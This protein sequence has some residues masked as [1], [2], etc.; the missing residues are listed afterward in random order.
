MRNNEN[1]DNIIPIVGVI[2][3]G[4]LSY[5][6]F[7]GIT[8]DKDKDGNGDGT[9]PDVPPVVPPDVPPVIT[10]IPPKPD[11]VPD[12]KVEIGDVTLTS[13]DGRT[14]QPAGTNVS[15]SIPVKNVSGRP[16]SFSSAI[17]VR[18]TKDLWIFGSDAPITGLIQGGE[19]IF[20]HNETRLY[21]FPW[22]TSGEGTFSIIVYVYS[23]S[24][25]I[26]RR[27]YNYSSIR[28]IIPV[29]LTI[30]YNP[31]NVG[32]VTAKYGNET[33]YNARV[34]TVA[35]GDMIELKPVSSTGFSRWSGDTGLNMD[36]YD[37][38]M[39]GIT[40]TMDR[41]RTIIANFTSA[42]S[43][44]PA[45]AI[46]FDVI[47]SGL[48]SWAT[49][50]FVEHYTVNNIKDFDSGNAAR[51][52]PVHISG[53]YPYGHIKSMIGDPYLKEIWLTTIDFTAED[54]ATYYLDFSN[55]TYWKG[56]GGSFE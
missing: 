30:T 15:F 48:P 54:G 44:P 4:L 11:P 20:Q 50:W 10:D 1:N 16:L 19:A 26:G 32:T 23:D 46:S 42:T 5:Q 53:V 31:I 18:N 55:N 6:V 40:V 41:D 45:T 38:N 47:P 13:P 29:V 51:I 21:T 56:S 8:T 12:I 22:R 24:K 3:I 9:T 37:P 39:Q 25:E 33:I 17:Q 14:V 52:Y 43:A 35:K 34:V 28:V 7:K 36:Y 49:L 2:T 27:E